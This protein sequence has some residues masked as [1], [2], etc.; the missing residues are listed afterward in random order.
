MSR[1]RIAT[2]GWA[3]PR[4][5]RH[6]FPDAASGL[7]RYAGRFDAAEINSSFYRA[8]RAS[9]W[10]RWADETP[11]GFRF[12]V[13]APK[14]IT[15]E[16]RLADSAELLHAFLAEA[17]LLGPKLGPILVQLPPS[18]AFDLAVAAGFLETLRARY[19]GPV[20]LE[21]RHPTWFEA[22]AEAL[23]VAAQVARVSADPPRHPADARPGGWP[24][25]AY[26]RLH[27]SPRMYYSA[28]DPTHLEA[29]A[30]QL[31]ASPAQEAW[32]VFDNTTSGAAAENALDLLE[33]LAG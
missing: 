22:G 18:L 21:P 5:V 31:R 33:M 24:G 19:D 6:R 28:Y 4:T 1:I 14:T 12:A 7:Q 8:H 25:L 15:H 10:A 32:C 13:K 9:T 2:A 3:A 20:A 16:R 27:G 29:L 11:A 26:W 17:R 23:L 30:A